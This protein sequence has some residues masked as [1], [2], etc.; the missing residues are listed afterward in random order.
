MF[1]NEKIKEI[2]K[3][4][5]L[6]QQEMADS[7]GVSKQ[8]FSKVENGLTDLSKEK[9][10]LLCNKYN[11]SVNWLLLDKGFMF[12]GELE[13]YEGFKESVQSLMNSNLRLNLFCKYCN[14]INEIITN[15]YPKANLEDILDTSK[16]VFISEYSTGKLKNNNSLKLINEFKDRQIS[17]EFKEKV[18]SEYCKIFVE[19]HGNLSAENN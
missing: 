14:V 8:Y 7:I 4:L 17:E 2:R 6:T 10:I 5:K 1:E 9:I 19:K 16:I 12:L 3:K 13:Q 18:I 11:I 15:K